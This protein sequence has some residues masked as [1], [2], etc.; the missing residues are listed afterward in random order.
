LSQSGEPSWSPASKATCFAEG[1]S[2]FEQAEHIGAATLAI[3]RVP[4]SRDAANFR[5]LVRKPLMASFIL[6]HLWVVLLPFRPAQ[7]AWSIPRIRSV[8]PDAADQ[9]VDVFTA[10]RCTARTT[11]SA[12]VGISWKLLVQTLD[13][14]AVS[15]GFSSLS[16][17]ELIRCPR[18]IF[19]RLHTGKSSCSNRLKSDARIGVHVPSHS[20]KANS[21]ILIV[22]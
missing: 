10:I 20:M 19:H 13:E 4:S 22:L 6:R 8:G 9:S 21:F 18:H 2:I 1:S 11:V 15:C 3:V 12:T 7:S 16:Q 5:K 14:V 17:S